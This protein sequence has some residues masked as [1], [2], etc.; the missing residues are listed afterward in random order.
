LAEVAK[1]SAA[2]L[3]GPLRKDEELSSVPR[4][5]DF[6]KARGFINI[7]A[8]V[9][10]VE[11]LA[12]E[13][14]GASVVDFLPPGVSFLH[15]HS[16][17]EPGTGEE[18]LLETD[19]IL[20][21]EV[22]VKWRWRVM[23]YMTEVAELPLAAVLPDGAIPVALIIRFCLLGTHYELH[24]PLDEEGGDGRVAFHALRIF[25][26]LADDAN[27]IQRW[28]RTTGTVQATLSLCYQAGS[29]CKGNSAE[30]LPAQREQTIAMCDL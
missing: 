14:G 6:Y 30:S 17:L 26:I 5:V 15:S 27:S 4:E 18:L 2:A 23:L 16:A 11:A 21:A 9:G 20:P 8:A 10:K 3:G 28:A 13:A 29:P 19:S 7:L 22:H 24:A 1:A 25:W 12:V